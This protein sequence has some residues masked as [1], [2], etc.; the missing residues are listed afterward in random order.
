[1]CYNNVGTISG[2]VILAN[3]KGYHRTLVSL[4]I[5]L[6]TS[7]ELKAPRFP[8]GKFGKAVASE[9]FGDVVY[10]ME[11]R[12]VPRDKGNGR[13]SVGFNF[14]FWVSILVLSLVL[15]VHVFS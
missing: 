9:S 2:F 3:D 1:M 5:K 4:R 14:E 7:R 12:W 8:L 6:P 13:L 11:Y 10:R 15:V